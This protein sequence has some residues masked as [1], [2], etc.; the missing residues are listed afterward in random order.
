VENRSISPESGGQVNLLVEFT[1]LRARELG[2]HGER[3]CV[4]KFRR[5]GRLQYDGERRI[6]AVYVTGKAGKL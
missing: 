3:E 6:G 4:M 2:I 5:D 1:G